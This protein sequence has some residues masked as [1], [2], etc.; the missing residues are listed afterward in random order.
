MITEKFKNFIF[1][2]K[3]DIHFLLLLLFLFTVAAVYLG[4]VFG[5]LYIDSTR[6]SFV[7]ELMVKGNVLHKDIFTLYNPFSY[8]LNS[9]IYYIFGAKFK[10]LYFASYINAFI[11]LFASYL[12]CRIFVS[13][14]FSFSVSVVILS[15][16]IF[17]NCLEVVS[18]IYP[19]SY[20]FAY[21]ATFFM[22]SVLFFLYYLKNDDK[23]MIYFSGLSLG[24]AYA[25]KPEFLLCFIPCFTV[26]LFKKEGFKRF[27]S[28]LFSVLLPTV[29][30][31]GVLFLQGM[32]ITDMK[33]FIEFCIGWL[34]SPEQIY[35]NTHEMCPAWNLSNL[36][37]MSEDF[38]F[39]FSYLILSAGFVS[40]FFKNKYYKTFGFLFLPFFIMFNLYHFFNMWVF[41]RYNN[42]F[43]FRVLLLLFIMCFQI[44]KLNTLKN[45]M[46]F[47]IAITGILSTA[48]VGFMPVH[49]SMYGVFMILPL[50]SI[51]LYFFNFGVKLS[52]SF[53][54][55]KYVALAMI[56][57]S[58]F[59]TG[60][61]KILFEAIPLS[62]FSSDKGTIYHHKKYVEVFEKSVEWVLNNTKPDESILSFPEGVFLNHITGRPTK[63]KYYQLTPNHISAYGEENIVKA[64][65]SDKPDY[66]VIN[67]YPQD[68]CYGKSLMCQDYGLLICDFMFQNYSEVAEFSGE[69]F[70]G[71]G[72]TQQI[73][74]LNKN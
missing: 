60:C 35:F 10:V 11:F 52:N 56:F 13:K 24:F 37:L 20:G 59:Y 17:S 12:I 16:F 41:D 9:L 39:M 40:L 54:Y 6:E 33:E 51:F 15:F 31:Y 32:T 21:A 23:K 74:K 29:L 3:N 73:Y 62:K 5:D 55:K 1:N 48:R 50:I 30:S 19:Y 72:F 45:K 61:S 43:S 18:F 65:D 34:N 49:K 69:N 28:Y 66:I 64:L 53:D 25:N 7:P 47:F 4:P 8:L 14:F 38:L 22:Y 70:A 26:L 57:M 68:W 58:L 44:F 46:L 71:D 63:N 67:E 42:Y 36:R 27:V 2:Y